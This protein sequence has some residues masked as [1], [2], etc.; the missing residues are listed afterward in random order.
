[1][2]REAEVG[3][4]IRWIDFFSLFATGFPLPSFS[5]FPGF[6]L[7]L[8]G[9]SPMIIRSDGHMLLHRGLH[10]ARKNAV[11]ADTAGVVSVLGAYRECSSCPRRPPAWD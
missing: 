7:V 4:C 8:Q 11:L 3:S 2:G 9:P 5:S 1:M 6:G 10:E